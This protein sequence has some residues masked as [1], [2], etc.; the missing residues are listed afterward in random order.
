MTKDVLAR[1]LFVTG[2]SGAGKSTA[3]K[4]LEDLGYEAVDNLP[5]RLVAAIVPVAGETAQP[6]AI[7]VDARTRDFAIETFVDQ[8]NA[9]RA[10]GG[11]RIDV[12][13]LACD[14]DVLQRRFTETRRR[15]PLAADRPV[16]DGI[17]QERRLIAPL[18]DAAD[19]VIDTSAMTGA[20]LKRRL[21]QLF[22]LEGGPPL[23]ILVTSFAYRHGLPREADL[24]FDVRFLANPHYEPAL[25]NKSGLDQDVVAYIERDRGF[26]EFFAN[27]NALLTPLL[28]RYAA[29]GKSYLT[30]AFGC[31]GGR[32]RSVA[33]AQRLGKALMASQYAVQIR[34]RDLS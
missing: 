18:R 28:P 1:L 32:H 29:E 5:L 26:A 11:L 30:I 7:G 19:H 20:D 24:V 4:A 14:D 23:S 25:R 17:Q 21:D 15:H 33:L 16:R 27:L 13:Y 9:L 31:T 22:V 10:H 34:H 12:V 3:L 8:L 2:L 6:L